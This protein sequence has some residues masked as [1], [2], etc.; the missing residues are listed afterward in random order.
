MACE[1]SRIQDDPLSAVYS[2]AYSREYFPRVRS[3]LFQPI[4]P[5]SAPA[6]QAQV[7][8]MITVFFLWTFEKAASG[9]PRLL[10]SSWRGTF[11]TQSDS[12]LS[13]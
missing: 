1:A 13:E 5:K 10:A 6:P 9:S 2:C 7:A 11:A 3:H 4:R 8:A 12:E